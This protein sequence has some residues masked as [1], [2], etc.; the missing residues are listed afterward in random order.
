M[1]SKVPIAFSMETSDPDDALALAILATHPQ[2][3]LV[4]VAV[5]PGTDQ[6]I[7]LVKC[8]LDRLGVSVP[9]GSRTPGYSK[10]CVSAFHKKWIGSWDPQDPDGFGDE[11]LAEALRK[12]PDLTIVSGAALTNIARAMRQDVTIQ[13]LVIQGGFA[14]DSVVAPEHR[15]PK[16]EGRETCPTFN[17]GGDPMAALEL[18]ASPRVLR[19]TLVSK[20]ACHGV[21]WDSPMHDRMKGLMNRHQ[22]LALAYAGMTKYLQDRPSGKAAHDLV[23][24][25]QAIDSSICALRQVEVYRQKGEWGSRLAEDTNTNISVSIDKHRFE[26]RLAGEDP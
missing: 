10:E 20:N 6:Q 7:G 8:I 9:V 16:F 12:Y 26:L 15:L 5:T 18:L 23:A 22:G 14:G 3:N 1:F 13:H 4:A 21:V 19:R 17:L 11:I 25:M 2:A 24:A